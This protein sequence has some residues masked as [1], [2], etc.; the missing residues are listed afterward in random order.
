VSG[1][2]SPEQAPIAEPTP[3]VPPAEGTWRAPAGTATAPAPTDKPEALVGAA[4]A[5][6]LVAAMI[7]KRLGRD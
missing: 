4:F 1:Y 7:L 2:A 6:G 3:T 5:G